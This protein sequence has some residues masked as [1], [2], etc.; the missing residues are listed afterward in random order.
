MRSTVH[1]NQEALTSQLH[2]LYHTESKVRGELKH[3]LDHITS[4]K[5]KEAIKK[6]VNEGESKLL[7]L[8][9][10]FDYL[11]YEPVTRKNEVVTRMLSE[12]YQML[13]YKSSPHL[14]D[15][16]VVS[17]IQNINYYKISAYRTAYLFAVEIEI[18]S[19]IDLLQQILESELKTE[20][21]LS[22]LAIEEFNEM[23][24]VC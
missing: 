4:N 7:K 5:I 17:C 13:T 16:L 2:G 6:Y 8:E 10:I 21:E 23:Q 9:R 15:M 11:M 1:S 20:T 24:A 14:K 22:T 3:C 12:T 19:V 18:D